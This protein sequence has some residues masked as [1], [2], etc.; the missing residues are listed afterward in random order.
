MLRAPSYPECFLTTP[1]SGITLAA[2]KYRNLRVSLLAMTQ[3]L[4]AI[5]T[6]VYNGA[7]FLDETMASVQAQTWKNLV[8]VVIDNAS[9]D[10]T[11]E[12]LERYR[13]QRV[14]VIVRRN[15][16][17]VPVRSNFELAVQSAP[18][19]A[20]YIRL[21]CADDTFYPSSTEEMVR[22]AEAHPEVGVV[23]SLHWCDGGV[24][25]FKWPAT[26]SVFPG[27]E[28]IR[29]F[30][31]NQGTIMPVQMMFRKSLSDQFKPFFPDNLKGAF[32]LDAMLRLLLHSDFG[33]VH[34]ELGFTRVHENSNSNVN[35]GTSTRAW[36]RDAL[37]FLRAYGPQ[38]M[39]SNFSA[40]YLRF[41]RYY[42]R[43]IVAWYLRDRKSPNLNIHYDALLEAGTPIGPSLIA[44]ALIDWV[45]CKFS[46]RKSWDGYPGWQG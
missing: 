30:L 1:V 20:N 34:K 38:S 6:P 35:F 12:I 45:L 23:G 43:R 36:T 22:L 9:T 17:T 10:S 32:D 19:N 41:R 2:S 21:L 42:V 29:R 14:P 16:T 18:D 13:N 28:A 5:V 46:V 26:Q 39:G 24:G 44:D 4:V 37:V 7:Q 15:Q 27:R 40:E 11:P 8:H 3:P 31:L 33:F 25:D